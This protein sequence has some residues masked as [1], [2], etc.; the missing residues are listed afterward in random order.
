MYHIVP[1]FDS[2]FILQCTGFCHSVV[3]LVS[4]NGYIL[5]PRCRE[6]GFIQWSYIIST[7]VRSGLPDGSSSC[8]IIIITTT[9]FDV[10]GREVGVPR[11][12]MGIWYGTWLGY[13][14]WY[15]VGLYDVVHSWFI[16]YGISLVYDMVHSWFIWYGT[17]LVYM[18]W[19]IVGLYDVV[20]S[21]FIWYGTSLVY[22]VWY[23]V[24]IWYGT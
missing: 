19:Y 8:I 11:S 17:W 1:E 15:I 13:M 6:V 12:M 10:E 14:V 21:W 2:V 3:R 18:V 24:G 16:W 7:A 4:P 22:M 9:P 5:F 20:H 23:I